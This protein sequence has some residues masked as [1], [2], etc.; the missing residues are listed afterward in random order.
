M[1][2]AIPNWTPQGLIPPVN[3]TQP[4]GADR[5]PYEVRLLDVVMRFAT[6]PKRIQIL[7]GYLNYRKALHDMGL[8]Q[9]FQWL[10]GS[11]AENIELLEQRAP[12]DVDVVSFLQIP[13]NFNPTPAQDQVLDTSQAKAMFLV[14]AYIVELNLLPLNN[15]VKQS[16][17][18]YSMW[19]HKR[20]QAWKGY[21]QVDLSPTEDAVT[22]SWLTAHTAGGVA[23]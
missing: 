5:S 21:L 6:S 16:A 8:Q 19:S 13:D 1:P 15:L 2:V 20:N 12:K 10:D 3:L 17:Y 9:G 23:P 22:Q 18:W 4:T 14:D 11:F 7:Q